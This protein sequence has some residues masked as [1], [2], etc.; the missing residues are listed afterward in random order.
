VGSE[1][2]LAI[3][4]LGSGNGLAGH[5]GY[6]TWVK[7]TLQVINQGQENWIDVGQVNG[8]YFFNVFGLGFD[9]HVVKAFDREASRGLYT[10]V[11]AAMASLPR[12]KDMEIELDSGVRQHK[13]SAFML[14]V[15]NGSQFGNDVQIAPGASLVD[16]QFRV[17]LV[18][19]FPKWQSLGLIRKL[20]LSRHIEHP[21]I[22]YF[23]AD[24]LTVSTEQPVDWQVDGESRGKAK[25]F[26][27]ELKKAALKVLVNPAK[28]I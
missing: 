16:G 15:C 24:R 5:L 9:A 7:T 27:I 14:D 21:A 2:A 17:V 4:P 26:E 22:R 10:Y 28:H 11:L 12:F 18:E 8:E 13:G 6:S 3:L 23:E 1:T 20:L 19:H 25:Q